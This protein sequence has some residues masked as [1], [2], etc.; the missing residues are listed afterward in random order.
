VVGRASP[1]GVPFEERSG[2]RTVGP[3]SPPAGPPLIELTWTSEFLPRTLR[4]VLV[5]HTRHGLDVVKNNTAL[6]GLPRPS[7][8][9]I[10]KYAGTLSCPWP[11][12]RERFSALRSSSSR[13]PSM[14]RW[15]RLSSPRRE[16]LKRAVHLR[17]HWELTAPH[18]EPQELRRAPSGGDE[19]AGSSL[20]DL[21]TGGKRK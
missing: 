17:R 15:S 4:A 2:S 9:C 3:V 10:V 5:E 12:S 6:R 13:E 18:L 19:T 14:I 11:S 21:M 8:L 1:M 20:G 16:M 7:Y